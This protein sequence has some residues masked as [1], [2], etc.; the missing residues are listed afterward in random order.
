MPMELRVGLGREEPGSHGLWFSSG[1][2]RALGH[3]CWR[4]EGRSVSQRLPRVWC[5]WLLAAEHTPGCPAAHDCPA[6]SR[7][8]CV[9]LQ[10]E[11]ARGG[12]PT[13]RPS[14]AAA[15][16]QRPFAKPRAGF[17]WLFPSNYNLYFGKNLQI[18][19]RKDCDVHHHLVSCAP[20]RGQSSAAGRPCRLLR[21][22]PLCVPPR[23]R[24]RRKSSTRYPAH[25]HGLGHLLNR[26]VLLFCFTS[27][28]GLAHKLYRSWDCP[29]L[30]QDPWTIA[31]PPGTPQCAGT[32]LTFLFLQPVFLYCGSSKQQ[33]SSEQQQA[34]AK[35]SLY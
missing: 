19:L 35:G 7:R 16:E 22:C 1:L 32:P 5:V 6:S 23:Y 27:L 2:H 17:S 34:R 4:R 31:D 12:C 24:E 15:A 9:P 13:S 25:V 29:A 11:A 10:D 30:E 26:F 28:V 18:F 20:S 8:W 3:R 14:T 21:V 33:R